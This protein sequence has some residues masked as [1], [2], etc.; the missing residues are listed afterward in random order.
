M[1]ISFSTVSSQNKLLDV[2]KS[3][4]ALILDNF[5][6]CLIKMFGTLCKLV[7]RIFLKNY[8]VFFYEPYLQNRLFTP[9][10][11]ICWGNYKTVIIICVSTR[12]SSSLRKK[13]CFPLRI[14]S[15]SQS[16]SAENCRKLHFLKKFLTENLIFCTVFYW[17]YFC[18][19]YFNRVIIFYKYIF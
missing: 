3:Q 10:Y 17:M 8:T 14:S 7:N 5:W 15:V 1:D 6:H 18:K 4:E 9:F 19:K 16:K 2:L 12:I 13:W 11:H